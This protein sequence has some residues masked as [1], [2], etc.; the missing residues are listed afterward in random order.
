[1]HAAGEKVVCKKKPHHINNSSSRREKVEETKKTSDGEKNFF[2]K[3][4]REDGGLFSTCGGR[5]I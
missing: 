5:R 3:E 4:G 1:M 2:N